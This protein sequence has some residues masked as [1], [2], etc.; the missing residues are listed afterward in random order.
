M[1]FNEHL[2]LKTDHAF[3]SPSQPRWLNYEDDKLI[4][5][6]SS[7]K[8]TQRGTILHAFAAQCISLGQRLEKVDK[9]INLYVNDSI[10]FVMTPEQVLYYSDYAWGTCDSICFRDKILRVHDYKSGSTKAHPEQLFVYCALF[11][12]EYKI[13]PSDIVFV[14]RIYQN[15]RFYEDHP[16]PAL[17]LQIM[18]IIVKHNKILK[19]VNALEG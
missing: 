10:D 6:Y 4:A 13:K 16:E 7:Y 17:I 8:A 19:E 3:L 15:N 18:D 1:I 2:N 9:T 14:T 12:L 11:C 5:S